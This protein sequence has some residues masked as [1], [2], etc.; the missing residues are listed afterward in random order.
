MR[1]P[2]NVLKWET[3][4]KSGLNQPRIRTQLACAGELAWVPRATDVVRNRNH[5]TPRDSAR[6][7]LKP[8][9]RARLPQVGSDKRPRA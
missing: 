1:S 3:G 5:W 2:N 4:G 6:G 9:P 7:R 8:P